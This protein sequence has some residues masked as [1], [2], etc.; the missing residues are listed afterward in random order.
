M[1]H[2][3]PDILLVYPEGNYIRASDERPFLQI[4]ESKYGKFMLELAVEADVDLVTAAKIALGSM[5]STARANLSVGPPYDVGIYLNEH[6]GHQRVPH[7]ERLTAAGQA[8]Q[9]LGARPAE[10]HRRAAAHH[11]GRR[12]GSADGGIAP[13]MDDDSLGADERPADLTPHERISTGTSRPRARY[14]RWSPP[15]Y[16]HYRHLDEGSVPDYIPALAKAP[17]DAFGVCV[18]GVHG[19]LFAIG[20]AEQEFTIQSISKLFVFA[21]VC[22]ALGPRGGAAQAGGQQPP[23]CPFDSVMGI[24]LNDGPHHEPHGERRGAGDDQ[25]RD[26]GEPRGP[27]RSHRRGLSVFAGRNLEMDEEV[28]ESEAATNFRNRGMAHLLNGY[29]RIYSDPEVAT[30][31][32]TRQC[33]LRVSARDLAVMGATLA[34]GGVNPHHRGAG[35][36]R[37]AAAGGCWPSSRPRGSTSARA[38][39]STTSA[40]PGRAASVGDW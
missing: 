10:R 1:G 21:L 30:D 12:H 38:T 24:E 19:R 9:G 4:G 23:A 40:C 16:E 39:G 7:R 33:A 32:Y 35:R 8:Q 20:D 25:P 34:D 2:Q 27:V 31:V 29:G 37:R 15:G 13:A 6:P 22:D 17:P 36:R 3:P 18:A 26:R 11:P 14:G 28:Y 5:M